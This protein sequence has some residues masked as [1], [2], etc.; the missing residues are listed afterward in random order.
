MADWTVAFDR[1]NR[2]T[3]ASNGFGSA[4]TF[5]ARARRLAWFSVPASSTSTAQDA[6]T[7]AAMTRPITGF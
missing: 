2:Q 5:C 3:F 6:L 7:S 1:N 4:M